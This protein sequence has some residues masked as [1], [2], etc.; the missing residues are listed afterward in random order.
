LG[1]APLKRQDKAASGMICSLYTHRLGFLPAA[2]FAG[3][4]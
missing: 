3:R 2:F 4:G 1:M